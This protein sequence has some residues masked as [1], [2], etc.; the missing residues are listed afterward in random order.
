MYSRLSSHHI[1]KHIADNFYFYLWRGQGNNC[2]TCLFTNVL[3]IPH[4]HVIIDPGHI[5]NEMNE[6]C[7]G[8]L[9]ESLKKDGFNIDDVGMIINTHSHIDHCQSNEVLVQKNPVQIAM[10]RDED[11]FRLTLGEKMNSMFGIKSP[12]FTTSTYLQEGILKIGEG[13]K[14]INLQVL[15]TPGHSPG[16]ICLY[17]PEQKLLITGD[18]VF[19]GSIGRTDFPGGNLSALK[20]SIKKLSK[21]DIEYLVPGHSTEFGDI[22]EGE[23]VQRNFQAIELYFG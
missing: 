21:L 19:Y 12:K 6:N 1:S 10:S 5:S 4:P 2:N 9:T 13:N 8:S 23:N 22:I 11:D 18:V 17:W 7:L 20:E 14:N 15:M 16:S 3:S